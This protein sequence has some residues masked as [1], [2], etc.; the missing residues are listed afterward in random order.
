MLKEG[1]PLACGSF[2]ELTAQGID[3]MSLISDEKDK[4]KKKEEAKSDELIIAE[5]IIARKRT[6][7]T[8]S[9]KSEVILFNSEVDYSIISSLRIIN[10]GRCAPA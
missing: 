5:Q 4:E 8:L 10:I 2:D 7:S 1:R 3:F 6:I 9:T